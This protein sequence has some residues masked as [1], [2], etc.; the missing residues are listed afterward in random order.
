MDIIF[1][2]QNG[3]DVSK[4]W[5]KVNAELRL[6]DESLVNQLEE[7]SDKPS[8]YYGF[9]YDSPYLFFEEDTPVLVREGVMKVFDNY[10]ERRSN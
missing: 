8:Y 1:Q 3:A 10:F 4:V 6:L 7:S 2:I 5:D 9:R